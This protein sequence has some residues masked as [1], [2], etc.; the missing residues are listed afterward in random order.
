MSS[1]PVVPVN[2][3]GIASENEP[4]IRP[5]VPERELPVESVVV[6]EPAELN[7][8]LRDTAESVGTAVGKAV[9]KV[10]EFPR[11]VSE[12]KERFT[13]VRG[14]AQEDAASTA[15]ELKESARQKVDQVRS[16]VQYYSREYPLQFLAGVGA[17]CFVLG[18]ALRIWRSSRRG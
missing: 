10:R 17:T 12:M 5:I 11:R 15:G 3:M 2:N 4:L 18:F 6:E 13:V 8:R 1:E 9:G 16:R 14:R 7:P